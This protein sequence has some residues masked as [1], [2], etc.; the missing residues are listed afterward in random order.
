MTPFYLDTETRST[1][2]IKLGEHRYAEG[3]ELIVVQYARGEAEPTVWDVLSGA[4]MPEDLRAAFVDPELIYIAHRVPFDRTI[5][6]QCLGVELPLERCWCTQ[7]QAYAH[8]LPGS[9]EK[10][11]A[12]IGLPQ[13][14]QKDKEGRRLIQLFCV[15]RNGKYRGTPE[16]HPEEW[17]RFLEYAHQDIVTL[18]AIHQKLPTWNYGLGKADHRIWQIDQQINDRGV[19]LDLELVDAA[20]AMT[21]AEKARLAAEMRERTDGEV[22]SATQRDK[23]LKL[24]RGDF[25]YWLPDLTE[26][27]IEKALEDD[28]LPV[29]VRGLLLNRLQASTSSTA[30]YPRMRRCAGP[31]G[32]VRGILQFS[33]AGRTR[34]WGGRLVQ[35]QNYPRPRIRLTAVRIAIQAIKAGVADLVT[36]DLMGL[37]R[38]CLRGTI[39][40]PP[41]KK[42]V[43]ADLANIEGRKGAWVAGEAWKLQAFRDYDAGVGPDLYKLAYARA[44]DVRTEDVD[45]NARQVGKVMELMLQYEGGVGAFVTGAGTYSIN[46]DEMAQ[47]AL[48]AMPKWAVDEARDFLKWVRDMKGNTYDLSDDAFIACDA[49]KRLWRR[50]H[51]KLSALWKT[52]QG[53][54]VAAIHNPGVDFT[55]NEHIKVRFAGAWLRIFLPSGRVLCYP[56]PRVFESHGKETFSFM[57]VDSFTKQWRRIKTYGGKLFE[58]CLIKGTLVLTSRGWVAIE[59][60]PPGERVWDGLNWVGTYGAVSRGVQKVIH[61]H[62]CWTTPDHKILTEEGW[63]HAS[64]SEGFERAA[65]RLPQGVEV[66]GIRREKIPVGRSMRVREPGGIL[67]ERTPEAASPGCSGVLRVPALADGSAAG[68]P[69]RHEPT[70]GVRR[71]PLHVGSMHAALPPGVEE[72]RGPWHQGLQRLAKLVRGFL[73]GHGLFVRRGVAPRESQQPTGL[74]RHQLPV[75][76][77]GRTSP[78]PQGCDPRQGETSGAVGGRDG[79]PLRNPLRQVQGRSQGGEAGGP[80]EA[81]VFDLLNCGPLQRFTVWAG[82]APLIVHNCI[83][84]LARDVLADSMPAVEAA[85]LP[86]VLSVHDELICEVDEDRDDLNGALLGEI[87]SRTPAWAPGLPLAAKGFDTLVYEK[88]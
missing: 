81:E 39:I 48:P 16:T 35:P 73:A 84:A 61:A 38:D 85:G 78:Q 70:P 18:R 74:L 12:A 83:Q 31:D 65:C 14:Q 56:S 49:I 24:I 4:R 69:P 68:D 5:L 67:G 75:G 50:N 58:N 66:P 34:R 77:A 20:I 64:E 71:V 46:L 6:R 37:A 33:A 10:L 63:K 51:P 13:D 76:H 32:R 15:P 42:L 7:A 8:A 1:V 57:G 80:F 82:G 36:D 21:G 59:H 88:R 79:G 28:E 40:A 62:G 22:T 60:V 29:E 86:I 44:F 19:Q 27:T 3:A 17:K 52:L 55:V 23:L 45:D 41:G 87:M 11:G 25:G 43:V 26:A 30:K 53:C 47:R 54:C 9:L 2:D 72:L